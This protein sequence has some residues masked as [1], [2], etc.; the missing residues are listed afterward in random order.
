MLGDKCYGKKK[1]EQGKGGQR[2]LDEEL[3]KV[4]ELLQLLVD[5]W[6]CPRQREQ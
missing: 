6:A 2:G 3:K 4:T 5:T 1:V